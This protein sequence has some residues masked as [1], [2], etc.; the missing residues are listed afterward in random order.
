MPEPLP[1]P[2][3]LRS[4]G[5]LVRGLSALFWALPVTLLVCFHTARSHPLGS[6]GVLPPLLSTAWILY[7][8]W[9]IGD[10]QKQ[11][12]VWRRALDNAR[13]LALIN[14]GLSPFLFWWSRIPSNPFFLAVVVSL[15]F[16]GLLFLS[17]LNS[18]VQRLGAMLPDETLRQE[19]RQFTRL[20]QILLLVTIVAG[21]VGLGVRFFGGEKMPFWLYSIQTFLSR[22][23]ILLL[24][25]LV[26][27]P[28]A[29][30]MALLW[31]TK[32]VILDSIF[33]G[34]Q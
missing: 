15:V 28:L 8:L 21:L 26:L 9:L 17:S 31:K 11:E 34:N 3:L 23:S 33:S 19:T 6:Y 32:E 1:Q 16:S 5:R 29:M 24:V 10:F 20:N 18:V 30:T 2:D 22:S 14:L 13:V 4:L 7:G 25:P 12:R 27:L